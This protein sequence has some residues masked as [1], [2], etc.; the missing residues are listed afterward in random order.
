MTLD[1]I[2]RTPENNLESSLSSSNLIVL[3]F[4]ANGPKYGNQIIH[5]LKKRNYLEWLDIKFSAIYRSLH[6]LEQHGLIT[7]THQKKPRQAKRRIYTIT[8]YGQKIYQLQIYRCLS[9][10]P[11]PKSLFDLG[12]SAMTTLERNQILEAL[13]TYR[14]KLQQR[15]D[16]LH[17][18][19]QILENI[20]VIRKREPNRLVG[21]TPVSQI[22]TQNLGVIHALFNRPYHILKAEI[23]W[24][25]K[26]IHQ[27]KTN[28]HFPQITSD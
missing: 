15:W 7:S 3:Y 2:E 27:I 19:V 20:T 8:P 21:K 12:V 18:I 24:L 13:H 23:Q 6:E 14:D 11:R 17:S 25:D 9:S 28:P 16:Y 10:P 1:T 22:P 4:I 5:L 26:F